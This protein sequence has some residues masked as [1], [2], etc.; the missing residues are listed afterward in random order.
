M[1]RNPKKAAVPAPLR[2][3]MTGCRTLVGSGVLAALER[4]APVERVVVFDLQPPDSCDPRVEY[5][6]VDLTQP[7]ADV[8]MADVMTD[9][10]VTSVLHA[11]FLSDPVRDT[12]WAH[13]LESVGTD[14]V[15]AAVG[16]AGVRKLVLSSSAFLYGVSHRGP[17]LHDEGVPLEPEHALPPFRDKVAAAQAVRRFEAAHPDMCVTVLRSALALGPDVDRVVPRFL[18]RRFVPVLMG[19]DPQLQFL[20]PDDLIDAYVLCL[21]EDHPGIFN[22]APDDAIALSEV[23]RIGGRTPVPVPHP[24]AFPAF[25]LLWAAGVGDA[26][27]SYL[28]YLRF[29]ALV[30]NRRAREVLGFRPRHTSVEVVTEY[31]RGMEGHHDE[32]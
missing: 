13:E 8:E 17:V 32:P 3:A 9:R 11:A 18:R 19:F 16:A 31:Y 1:K 7:G 25:R 21:R 28:A 15:L 10:G 14:Y 20:H 30:D 5:H 26:H 22:I 27:P 29:S 24:L 2:L 4:L 12:T 23:L 6:Q